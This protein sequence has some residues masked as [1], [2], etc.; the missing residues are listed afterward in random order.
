MNTKKNLKKVIITIISL[1]V[2]FIASL[3]I[4]DRATVNNQYYIEEANIQIPIFVYH[5]I[6]E[7]KSE[8]QYDYMQTTK[9]TFEEQIK[10]LQNV[11]Y[12]FIDY[13]DLVEYKKGNKKLY[14]KSCI[15]TF[16]DG[17]EGVYENAYPI[18]QK[19]NI[20]FAMFVIIDNMNTEGVITWQQA[21]EM[22]NSG[23]VT[24]AS[25]SMDHPEF[26]S[27][28]TEEAVKNVDNSYKSIEEKLGSTDT[29]VFT[30]PYGLHTNEQ[31]QSLKEKGYVQN[32]TDNKINKSKKL[33]LY[34]LHRCYPL[35]D[36]IYE[37]MAKVL[38]R[39]IR[40]D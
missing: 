22:K 1:V 17:Y 19:Y 2:I 29:K 15:I 11:G 7:D 31:L 20:P 25:H 14:K 28:S 21:E 8:I 3:V 10:G 36:S 4:Y 24:I 33:N 26:T 13:K 38:Y 12:H 35:N 23:L 16:D 30:Y 27:L 6:V 5:N 40:Y 9:D 39:S 32:L 34:G 18:A 37:I